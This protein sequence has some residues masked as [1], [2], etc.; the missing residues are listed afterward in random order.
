MNHP[1]TA[2]FQPA[3]ANL[4][5]LS[6]RTRHLLSRL[7]GIRRPD[8]LLARRLGALLSDRRYLAIGH[9]LYFGAWPD[10][11]HPRT[12]NEHIH[13]YMLRCRS[14]LLH[15]AADKALT[16]DHVARTV[17]RQYLVPTLGL[18]PDVAS[19][20]IR[21]LPRPCVLKPTVGSGQ[22]LFLRTGEE[23]NLCQTRL[24]LQRWLDTE[25]SR[26]NR[27]WC[28][29]RLRGKIIA[30]TLLTDGHGDV[31]AD[32]KLY[33]IGGAVRFI[34]VDRGR[35][36]QHTRNLYD[37]DWQLLSARLSLQNHPPDPRPACLAEMI[38][39]TLRLAQCFE[40]LRVDC[41]IVDGRLYVGEL[42]NYPGAGFERFIPHAYA[43]EL[44]A[45]WP[46]SG[47]TKAERI[48]PRPRPAPTPR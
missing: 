28:Y 27:E 29:D 1:R 7:L 32:Y 39:I 43:L 41:Y 9:R 33:V 3:A 35:F 37:T 8:L 30:E 5:S 40:F 15:I 44:G 20:P 34:Q 17:G 13:A 11:E 24:T 16:R 18:W 26:M 6:S 46:I 12:I 14:P 23:I 2:S 42:T 45:L 21:T 25:Y 10:Y 19:I 48:P 22:V 4:P 38:D 31:P 47:R 36:R